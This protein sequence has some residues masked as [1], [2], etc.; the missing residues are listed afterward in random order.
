METKTVNISLSKEQYDF[1][2]TNGI[3]ISKL[4]RASIKIEEL[5]K[6]GN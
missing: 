4:V 6:E 3:D 2:T 1:V 5:N